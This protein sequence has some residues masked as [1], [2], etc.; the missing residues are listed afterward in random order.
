MSFGINSGGFI[1]TE[2]LEGHWMGSYGNGTLAAKQ[3]I[4]NS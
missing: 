3:T 1:R 4:G 2:G